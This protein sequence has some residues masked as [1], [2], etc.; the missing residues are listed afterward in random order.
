MATQISRDQLGSPRA[1]ARRDLYRDF[2]VSILIFGLYFLP[3]QAQ[4]T[5]EESV[6][7]KVIPEPEGG[8]TISHPLDTVIQDAERWAEFWNDVHPGKPVPALDFERRMVVATAVGG[9]TA[10]SAIKVTRVTRKSV[11]NLAPLIKV[12]T[13]QLHKFW[14]KRREMASDIGF[15][16]CFAFR[17][18]SPLVKSSPSGLY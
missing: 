1:A 17:W 11:P 14:G 16:E 2:I 10:T 12:Y 9:G 15:S 3:A 6:E 5:Q 8:K 13:F 7:F 4:A 18:I